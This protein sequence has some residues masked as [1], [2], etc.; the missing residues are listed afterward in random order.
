MYGGQARVDLFDRVAMHLQTRSI[1]SLFFS[2]VV[3]RADRL[4]QLAAREVRRTV[5][6]RGDGAADA[7]RLVRVVRQ[8]AVIN[9]LP[10]FE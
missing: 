3:E 4:G 5:Q 1:G 8:P 9:R 2:Y 10:R 7:V 6:H